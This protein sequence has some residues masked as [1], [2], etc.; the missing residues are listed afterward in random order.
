MMMDASASARHTAATHSLLVLLVC[1]SGPLMHKRCKLQCCTRE[2]GQ[3]QS[4]DVL[5]LVARLLGRRMMQ[6]GTFGPKRHPSP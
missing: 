5:A 4:M 2:T 1:R 6:H 3:S